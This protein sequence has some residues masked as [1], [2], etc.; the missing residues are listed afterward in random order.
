[1][2][3]RFV[4]DPNRLNY[5]IEQKGK[6][7]NARLAQ[8][9]QATLTTLLNLLPSTYVSTVQGPNYTNELKAVAVEISKIELALEDIESDSGY[10]NTRSDFLYSIIGYLVFLNGRLPRTQFD[11]LEFKRFLLSVIKIYFQ[12]SIPTSIKEGVNLFTS[13]DVTVTENYK[14]IR[15][16]ASGYDISDQFGFQIDLI[17]AAPG[18]VFAIDANIRL[19]LDIIRP[20][21]TLFRIRYIFDD[22]YE[23]NPENPD[24][25]GSIIDRYRW[26]LANYYYE[27]FRVYP[28]GI[29]DRDRLGVKVNQAV[30]D[31]DHSAD[32]L[33]F[34][35]SFYQQRERGDPTMLIQENVRLPRAKVVVQQK[36]VIAF[37]EATGLYQ[38]EDVGEPEEAYNL[39]TDAGRVAIHTY[40]YGTTAQR[41]A[42]TLGTGLNFIGISSDGTPAAA[43][44]TTLAGELSGNGLTRAQATVTLPTGSGTTTTIQNV[45]TYT[46]VSSQ[47]VQKTALFDAASSGK[48]AHEI[49]FSQRTLFQNDTLTVTFSITLS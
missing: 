4:R 19:V 16:G 17:G 13:E 38:Y 24:S 48:M 30:T 5:T 33:V 15:A 40:I 9:A 49:L 42:A 44:D 14:L 10:S 25:P 7:Y 32:F 26:R 3:D 8:R 34:R 12:G 21:H 36:R 6:E 29:R 45:F 28:S 27:D 39:V 46:N 47:T 43:G 18:D 1:M 22:T 37:D 11:D 2:A 41:S 35:G 31:E 20:A 23:P